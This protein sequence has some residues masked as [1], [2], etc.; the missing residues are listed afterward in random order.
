MPETREEQPRKNSAALG[1]GPGSVS[2]DTH[3][4]AFKFF[5]ELKPK[6]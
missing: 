5:I 3:N 1:Q 4:N 6:K 2:R